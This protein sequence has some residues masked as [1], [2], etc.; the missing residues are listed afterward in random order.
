MQKVT[1]MNWRAILLLYSLFSLCFSETGFCGEE[2]IIAGPKADP[3][4]YDPGVFS[5]A[6]VAIGKILEYPDAYDLRIVT[7]EGTVKRVELYRWPDSLGRSPSD[8]YIRL[9]CRQKSI[10]L[11]TFILEDNTGSLE[12]G[13]Q[14]SASCFP[15]NAPYPIQKG[16]SEGD[17]IV[18][19]V[20]IVVSSEEVSGKN[21]RTVGAIF[22]RGKRITD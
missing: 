11:Y 7:L 10:P 9:R 22:G 20:E 5:S 3:R 12:V 1:A 21:H 13:V 17:R 2:P 8:S 14:S 6:H 15:G 4:F 18:A 16:V 19:E